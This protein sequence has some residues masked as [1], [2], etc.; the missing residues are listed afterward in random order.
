MNVCGMILCV[1]LGILKYKASGLELFLQSCVYNQDLNS[2]FVKGLSSGA[3]NRISV[4]YVDGC[5]VGSK[6]VGVKNSRLFS[7][8]IWFGGRPR[9][10]S[11]GVENLSV[12][13]SWAV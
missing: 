3:E 12:K 4:M 11:F 5:D 2:V 6:R 7:L 10:I 1:S 8:D 13:D 9:C